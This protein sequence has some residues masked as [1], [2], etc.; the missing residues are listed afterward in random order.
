MSDL[1]TRKPT[2][3]MIEL[4]RRGAASPKGI[5]TLSDHNDRTQDGILRRDMAEVVAEPGATHSW[6][7]IN[8]RGRAYLAELDRAQQQAEEAP[9]RVVLTRSQLY[10]EVARPGPAWQWCYAYAVDG[11]PAITYGTGLA[12]LRDMLRRKFGRSV[13]IEESWKR[14]EPVSAPVA[15]QEQQEAPERP[16]APQGPAL[17]DLAKVSEEPVTLGTGADAVVRPSLVV[18]A[19]GSVHHFADINGSWVEVCGRCGGEGVTPFKWV[20]AGVCFGCNST[21]LRPEVFS[22]TRE[23]RDAFVYAWALRKDRERVAAEK[24]A[25]RVHAKRLAERQKWET[26][27]GELLA[28][29]RALTPD[30][31]ERVLHDHAVIEDT[32]EEAARCAPG[33]EVIDGPTRLTGEGPE[34]GRWWARLG[35][36]QVWEDFGSYGGKVAR[37]IRDAR[38]EYETLDA[39]ETAFL[40]AVMR[41]VSAAQATSR[42]AGDL[43]A[44]VSVTGRVKVVMSVNGWGGRSQRMIV[45]EGTGEHAGI[46]LK[47]YTAAGAAWDLEKGQEGVTVTGTVSKHTERSGARETTVKRPKIT[48]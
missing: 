7:V 22:G 27:N 9:T 18:V 5:M 44:V 46:T 6:L 8:D 19:Y 11:A 40:A 36:Y 29:A 25:A 31:T 16:G 24:K 38:S 33:E 2:A 30:S 43:D 48:A 23:E 37:L 20:H 35:F 17:A 12:S 21:G 13:V 39:R 45:L 10:P 15:A 34:S 32:R 41:R 47:T 26:A 14:Q 42:Y 3:P 28:W 4:L 1:I